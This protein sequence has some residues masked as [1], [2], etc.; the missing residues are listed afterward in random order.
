LITSG[1]EYAGVRRRLTTVQNIETIF[2][3]SQE[4]DEDERFIQ[5]GWGVAV[6]AAVDSAKFEGEGSGWSS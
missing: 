3:L 5:A 6:S 4:E 1:I 2:V